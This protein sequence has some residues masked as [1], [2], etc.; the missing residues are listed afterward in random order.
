MF[1]KRND[2][3]FRIQCA[4]VSWYEFNK[5]NIRFRM[6]A[7]INGANLPKYKDRRG[8]VYSPEAAKLKRSGMAAGVADLQIMLPGG[9]SAWVEV[10]IPAKYGPS[11][12]TGKKI[13]ARP[14]GTQSDAQ[15]AFE[16]DC[17]ELGHPYF[18]VY[19]LDDFIKL[20][21][22]GFKGVHKKV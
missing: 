20:A 13:V 1:F 11:Q 9:K 21:N 16:G 15:A 3:E 10:K 22:S 12:K 6:F 5:R 2:E 8:K 17:I 4:I 14:K 18:I 7:N 19:S